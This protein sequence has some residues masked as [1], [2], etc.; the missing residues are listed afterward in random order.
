MCVL[1]TC[2]PLCNYPHPSWLTLSWLA[3]SWKGM[4]S[5]CMASNSK[6]L[7]GAILHLFPTFSVSFCVLTWCLWVLLVY[8]TQP[9]GLSCTPAWKISPVLVVQGW[10]CCSVSC[11]PLPACS[12]L[13]PPQLYSL[14]FFCLFGGTCPL[15]SRNHPRILPRAAAGHTMSQSFSVCRNQYLT[16]NTP[17]PQ[18]ALVLPV[19]R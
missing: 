4:F 2:S 8:P 3:L 18:M 1:T 19:E 12:H 6:T 15:N 14:L 7:E 10:G 5:S 11:H 13:G 16:T 9:Q 17:M